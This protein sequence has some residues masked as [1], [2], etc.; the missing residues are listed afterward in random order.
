MLVV[1]LRFQNL[2]LGDD[3][4]HKVDHLSIPLGV[5]YWFLGG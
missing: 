3:L 5:C 2:P 1:V 4:R